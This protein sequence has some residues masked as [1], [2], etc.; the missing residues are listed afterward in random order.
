MGRRLAAVAAAGAIIA[1]GMGVA[2]PAHAASTYPDLIALPNGWRPEGIATG[3]GHEVYVGS[4]G[5][6][7]VYRADL[8]TGEGAVVVPPQ[9]GRAAVGL[10]FD[11]RSGLLFVA[12]GGAGDGYVYDAASGAS[13]ASYDFTSAPTFINDVIVTR[14][15][16]WFTDSMKPVLYRVALSANGQPSASFTTVPL[17]GDYVQGAGFNVNGIA[18]TPNGNTLII[19]QSGTGKL[20]SVAADSGVATLIDLGGALVTAGDGILLAGKT[21]YVVRN[22]L[23]Q[24]AVVR[25]ASDLQS[26]EIV[27]VLADSDFQV[28]TTIAKF[29]SRLYAVNARFGTPPTPDTRYDIVQVG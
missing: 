5:T 16:A 11:E 27:E 7:A 17:S 9:S 24:V 28:P 25:L 2:S 1:A 26:G 13:V 15:A 6:G 14:D 19:V 21:L 4:L 22:Q 12:G 23:N 10:K 18:A 29:G 3:G 8:R 20:F